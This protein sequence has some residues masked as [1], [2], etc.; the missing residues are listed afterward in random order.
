MKTMLI[1]GIV[2]GLVTTRAAVACEMWMGPLEKLCQ[3]NDL[4]VVVKC[5]GATEIPQKEEETL[6]KLI[7]PSGRKGQDGLLKRCRLDIIEVI[8]N[9]SGEKL[10]DTM[11]AVAYF[12]PPD[13]DRP[14]VNLRNT[15]NFSGGEKYILILS[16]LAKDK[17][18]YVSPRSQFNMKASLESVDEVRIAANPEKWGWSKPVNG[19]SLAMNIRNMGLDDGTSQAE[20][21]LALR[22]G[23]SKTIEF[24]VSDEAAKIE[25]RDP[26][27]GSVATPQENSVNGF[28][29]LLAS[30]DPNSAVYPLLPNETANRVK[31]AIKAGAILFVRD[32]SYHFKNNGGDVRGVWNVPKGSDSRLWSGRIATERIIITG[33]VQRPQK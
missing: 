33:P 17:D 3:E 25:A 4:V 11:A 6:A 14:R 2:T 12:D 5:L 29:P 32:G 27:G 21:V 30:I 9:N 13:N 8:R 31:A 26:N 28:S 22:N 7:D 1:I 16:R 24:S 23:T 15:V 18:Y 19:L 10:A 20:V